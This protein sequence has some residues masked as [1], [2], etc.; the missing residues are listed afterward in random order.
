M[1]VNSLPW[2]Y[3][4][5][6]EG[7]QETV[8]LSGDEWHH[9]HHVLRMSQGEHLVLFNGHGWCMEGRIMETSKHQ[10]VIA[11]LHDLAPLYVSPRKYSITLAFAPTKNIDRTEFALEKLVELGVDHICFL[12]CEHSERTHL[13]MD[14][15]EKIILSAAKQSRKIMLPDLEGPVQPVDYIRHQRSSDP[16]TLLL[17]G[18]LDETSN[19]LVQNYKPGSDVVVLIGPEGGFS[20]TE[21]TLMKAEGATAVTLGPHRLRVETAVIA[22][23]TAIHIL[24]EQTPRS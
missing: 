8:T 14:R 9:C 22:T 7:L 10:G 23:C 5:K 2:Y 6:P 16:D 4:T 1:D 17:F 11:L 18:H 3:G 15:M 20:Q 24:N 19:P 21:T 12:D 13:R